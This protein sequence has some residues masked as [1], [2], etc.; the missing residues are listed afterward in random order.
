MP[1]MEEHAKRI[2]VKVSVIIVALLWFSA[3][4][5]PAQISSASVPTAEEV[6]AE[7]LARD[8]QREAMAGGYTGS[9]KYVLD[10][11]RLH[12]RAEML[13]NIICNPD[14]SKHFEIVSEEGW[15][16]ANKRVLRKMVESES[17][18][19][20]PLTRPKTRLTTE[21][22]I[23]GA[24]QSDLLE[25]RAAYAI[26]VIPKRHDKYL[27][28]GRIWVDAEDYALMRAEGKPAKSPSFWTRSVHFVQQYRRNGPFWFPQ[29]TDS[30]TDVLIF[31]T[32]QVSITYFG[33][34][35][36]SLQARADPSQKGTAGQ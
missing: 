5:S 27:F 25:G 28:E 14:G 16:A 12:K 9:R 23:F 4:I 21:N 29:A 22:Y 17:E 15:S 8:R 3:S 32:T 11:Q 13:V 6:I 35:P 26:D 10:N 19:S 20:L 31:G 36:R 34:T 18:T 33:Y 30:V 24:A 1:G 2:R 7:M